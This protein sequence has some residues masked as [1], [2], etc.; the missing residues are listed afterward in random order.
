M[1]LVRRRAR[2]RGRERERDRD[3]ERK[4]ERERMTEKERERERQRKKERERE[5]GDLSQIKRLTIWTDGKAK[6]GR[7]REEKRRTGRKKEDTGARK[8]RNA[9]KHYDFPMYC[10][11]GRSKSSLA[12]AAGAEPLGK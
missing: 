10:G 8:R 2:E 4:R 9:A 6:V 7:V 12:E 1:K 11:P 3:R 5:R